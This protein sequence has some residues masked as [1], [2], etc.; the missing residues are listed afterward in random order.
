MVGLNIFRKKKKANKEELNN[1]K[2]S[3]LYKPKDKRRSIFRRY[4]SSNISMK[5]ILLGISL[6]IIIILIFTLIYQ[7]VRNPYFELSKFQI[8]GNRN[9]SDEEILS[10]INSEIGRHIYII[11]TNKIEKTIIEKYPIIDGVDIS[12]IWP[13]KL[14]IKISE[15][16][17][18]VVV[19]NL[20][21]AYLSDGEGQIIQ[22]I[23]KNKVDFS[24]EKIRIARGY[25]SIDDDI[26]RETLL[27]EFIAK[28]GLLELEEE[29][30]EKIIMEQ[31]NFDS[32]SINKKQ[33]I[34]DSLKEQ[35]IAESKSYWDANSSIA[36]LSKYSSYPRVKVLNNDD[37]ELTDK[38][39]LDRLEITLE[40]INF[41]NIRQIP[42]NDII[43]EGELLVRVEIDNNRILIFGINRKSSIQF[44]DLL[45]VFADLSKRGKGFKEIDVSASKVLVVH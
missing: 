44:E 39:D 27:N 14:F 29:E 5:K 30:R 18:K 37:L 28:M 1:F 23:G 33:E 36:D 35:Y 16:E 24:D 34:L 32:I 6:I 3:I 21:G 38:V 26:V 8:I 2:P 25:G 20:N 45:I 31:F 7:F 40:I 41:L 12:K 43:W 17:A 13:D 15:R 42:I 9:I 4:N 11:D 22:I 10:S 19:V